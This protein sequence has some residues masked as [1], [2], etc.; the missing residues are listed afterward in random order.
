[1]PAADLVKTWGARLQAEGYRLT[2]QRRAVLQ[3]LVESAASLSP[4]EILQRARQ[5]VPETG[6]VTV[7]R[8]LEVLTTCGAARKVHRPDGCHSYAPASEGH[9]HHII[10]ERCRAVLEFEGCDLGTLFKT[11]QRRTGYKVQAHW[12]ELFGLCPACRQKGMRDKQIHK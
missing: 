8:T 2:A 4:A 6:L 1:M 7:Y 12:L 5:H 3:V 10:C 9:M 11:V